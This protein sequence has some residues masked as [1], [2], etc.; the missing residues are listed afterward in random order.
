VVITEEKLRKDLA[1]GKTLF[2]ICRYTYPLYANTDAE[3]LVT[4]F[5]FYTILRYA[6]KYN[7]EDIYCNMKD[8]E[9]EL[10]VK[11]IERLSDLL[12]K[13]ELESM[14]IGKKLRIKDIAKIYKIAEIYINT[15]LYI[16][17]IPVRKNRFIDLEKE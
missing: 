1:N 17:D 9:K 3:H 13:E 14:Y 11:E 7:I 10:V 5:P 16:Y 12:D 8:Y 15:L 4:R 2:D 6:K